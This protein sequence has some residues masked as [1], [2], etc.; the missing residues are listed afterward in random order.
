MSAL[1]L[2]SSSAALAASARSNARQ[3]AEK[4]LPPTLRDLRHESALSLTE[5]AARIGMHKGRL[6][7]LERGDRAATER[8]LDALAEFYNAPLRVVLAIVVDEGGE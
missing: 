2:R 4:P 6:S 1:R 5:A 3:T 7:E 8:E